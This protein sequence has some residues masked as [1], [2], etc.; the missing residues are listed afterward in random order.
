MAFDFTKII[1]EETE[2]QKKANEISEKSDGFKTV[3][4]FANGRLEFK[5]IGNEPSGLLYRELYFHEFWADGK[6]Q[7]VPCLHNMYSMECPICNAVRNIQETF[8][9]KDIFGK[10]GVKK[11]GIMFAKLLSVTPDNYFGDNKTPPKPGDIV[12]FMFPKSV[13]NSLRNLI[14]EYGEECNT[15]FT[16]NTTRNVTLKVETQANGFFGY[17]FYVKNNT[18]TLCVNKETGEPDQVAFNEFMA[19]MPNLKE[20]RFASAPTEDYMKI[21]RT[22]V[23]EINTKYY[24][25]NINESAKQSFVNAAPMGNIPESKENNIASITNIPSETVTESS[26]TFSTTTVEPEVK[27]DLGERPPCFGDNKYDEACSKC[28]WDSQCV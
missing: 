14:I 21:H 15:L 11:Q 25:S 27:N 5:F 7:K 24:G 26:S 6:K 19:K 18:T 12:L 13:I 4:P 1:A 16:D 17:T 20:T 3:Y 8:D 10:Y 23:E 22:V 2:K 9:D 28:P